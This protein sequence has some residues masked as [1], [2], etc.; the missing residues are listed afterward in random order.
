MS[1]ISKNQSRIQQGSSIPVAATKGED[2]VLAAADS[3]KRE[4][5]ERTLVLAAT[6]HEMKTPIAVITGYADL[7]L[8]GH[9]G[10]LSDQQRTVVYEIQQN[11]TR[12]QLFTGSFL[13]FSASENGH[14]HVTR[15]PGC[16]NDVVAGEIARWQAP[17]ASQGTELSFCPSGNLPIVFFDHVKLEHVIANLLENALKFTPAGGRVVVTTRG[18]WWERRITNPGTRTESE[19]RAGRSAATIN[20]VRVDVTDN[21][22]GIAPEHHAE[23]FKEF[24]QLDHGPHSHGVGLGLAVSKKL[25]EAHGGRIWVESDRGKGSTFSLL[26][27]LI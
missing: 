15:E 11:A 25:V 7:L 16:V 23:I 22:P 20:C 1:A 13:H 2:S 26:L 19:R 8:G 4:V 14:L 9:L 18:Y 6:A 5:F 12:L 24:L 17:F 3:T 21:G 10:E 27:P